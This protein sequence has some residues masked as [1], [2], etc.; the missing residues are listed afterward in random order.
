P[1]QDIGNIKLKKHVIVR[2]FV[3]K[4]ADSLHNVKFFHQSVKY[5]VNDHHEHNSSN[6]CPGLKPECFLYKDP[7][8]ERYHL[9]M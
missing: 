4:I 5:E 7:H 6:S 9:P 3:E 2:G 1:Q 8:L